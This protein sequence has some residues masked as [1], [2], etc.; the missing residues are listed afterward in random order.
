MRL[1]EAAQ[2]AQRGEADLRIVAG[3]G[4]RELRNDELLPHARRL[5]DELSRRGSPG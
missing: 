3:R 1:E 4:R 2:A 5:W